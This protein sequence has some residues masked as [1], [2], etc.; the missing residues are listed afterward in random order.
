MIKN[1]LTACMAALSIT[2][3]MAE[4]KTINLRI[5]QTSDVH[6]CFFPYDFIN[7]TS[8]NGSMARVISYVDSLR[9]QYG[10]NLILLDNGDILQGQP[11]SYYSNYIKTD[12]ENIAAKV[13]NYMQYDAQTI[14]NHDMETGHTVYDKWIKE[15]KCPVL[16]ANVISDETGKPYFKPYTIVERSGIKVAIL[17]MLTPAIPN[18]LNQNLWKG[19]HFED[20]KQC[21][22]KW[23]NYLKY[24]EHADIIIGL[25]HSGKEGGISTPE[26]NE[27]AAMDVAK[28]VPG[29]DI[30]LFG[31][32][33]SPFGNTIKNKKG[34]PV[35][36][37]D[38]SCNAHQVSDA[39]IKIVINELSFR[40]QKTHMVMGKSIS[41][42]LVNI[43]NKPENINYM[44]YFKNDIDSIKKFT[45]KKIGTFKQ[46]VNSV[47]GFFGSSAFTDFIHNIQLKLTGADIS[48][49]APLSMDININEGDVF[50][51]DMFKLYKFENQVYV[52]NMTGEEIRKH[53]E[54]SY[55]LWTNTME[56]S[57]DHILLLDEKTIDDKQKLG[58]K[59]FYFNF[60]SA[61]GINYTVDVSKPNGCKV[62]IQSMS[63]GK[64]FDENATYKVVMNSYRGNGG[65]E[66]LTKGAGIALKDIPSR[67][68]YQSEKDLR[69]YIIQE[70]EKAGIV[71]PKANNNWRF[72][73]E[74]W[75][76]DAITR[77]KLLVF[78]K[79]NY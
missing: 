74:L 64:P 37:L 36:L 10:G 63:N 61:A 3:A 58:L 9:G 46:S 7:M 72:I 52:L 24:N 68:I 31:H 49:N 28:N 19:M 25:F 33:H 69:Y 16:A 70:I 39:Q 41:G 11:T 66:L 60:D 51:N 27:N 35:L 57:R 32:D 6:G 56:S 14:G 38:P 73:P 8:A 2:T 50:M 15:V 45:D 76:R 47:D 48:F 65:G 67:I 13:V 12:Q 59:N 29:F 22:E 5:I 77:D 79:K 1:L 4:I 42:E 54:M 71:T 30:V 55:D 26:Y 62:T 53:L 18:W 34:E 40:N 44:A 78:G 43:D 75:T 17:G 20:I 21:S 23:V